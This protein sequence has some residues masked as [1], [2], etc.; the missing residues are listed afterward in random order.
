[1][2]YKTVSIKTPIYFTTLFNRVSSVTNRTLQMQIKHKTSTT[3]KT[4]KTVL[5]TWRPWLGTHYQ[6]NAKNPT[7]SNCL[8]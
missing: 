4:D 8:R 1:M 3:K 2:V 5:H 7:H 6:V